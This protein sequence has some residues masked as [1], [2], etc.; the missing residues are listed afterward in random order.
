MRSMRTRMRRVITIGAATAALALGTLVSTASSAQ[1]DTGYQYL[2]PDGGLYCFLNK[3]FGQQE[4]DAGWKVT[5][6]K[7]EGGN[8]VEN[9]AKCAY[10]VYMEAEVSLGVWPNFQ[11]NMDWAAACNQQ[12]PGS[13]LEWTFGVT[14]PW[15]CKA[16]ADKYFPPPSDPSVTH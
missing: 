4:Q 5:F 13:T 11:T 14:D 9:N 3:P 8:T 10:D 6:K 12:Y 1:A 2:V 15:R 7:L 16:P